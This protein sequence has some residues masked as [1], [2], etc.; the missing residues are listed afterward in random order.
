MQVFLQRDVQKKME[1]FI[2]NLFMEEYDLIQVLAYL[3]IIYD[4]FYS[5]IGCVVLNLKQLVDSSIM[6]ENTW[7]QAWLYD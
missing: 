4:F 7:D 2:Q 3:N 1:E 6:R 5:L